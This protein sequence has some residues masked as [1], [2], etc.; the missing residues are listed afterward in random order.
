MPSQEFQEIAKLR[1]HIAKLEAQ[2]HFLY[3]HLG[4][5]FVAETVAIEDAEIVEYLKKGD[6]LGAI[7][8]HRSIYTSNLEDAKRAVDDIRARTGY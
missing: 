4:V 3:K 2:I 6:V 8:A 5:T 7:R 1:S